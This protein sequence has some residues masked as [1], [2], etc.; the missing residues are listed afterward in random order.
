MKGQPPL[1]M[2]EGWRAPSF[3]TT[4]RWR[5]PSFQTAGR[6]ERKAPLI[7]PSLTTKRWNLLSLP[8]G[9]ALKGGTALLSSPR[10]KRYCSTVM[11][12]FFC[13]T[14]SELRNPL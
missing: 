12:N 4:G 7:P 8:D 11:R 14:K 10:Y 5:A 1:P 9:G 3:Q 6:S 13:R 2:A